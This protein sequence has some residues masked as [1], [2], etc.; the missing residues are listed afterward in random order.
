MSN[1]IMRARQLRHL[2]L[3]DLADR[4]DILPQTLHKYESGSRGIGAKLMPMLREALD[5]SAAYLR[6]EEQML[7]VRDWETGETLMCPIMREEA[8]EGY[9]VL[10]M[11][12]DAGTA[13]SVLM[14][15]GVQFTLSD[16]QGEQV[17]TAAQITDPPNGHWVDAWGRDAVM[18]DGLPRVIL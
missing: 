5:V 2:R 12:D 8:I 11:V 4:L 7:P 9:G 6:G 3:V 10:Y 16:W 17:M 13:I 1:N 15:D 14:A 18:L